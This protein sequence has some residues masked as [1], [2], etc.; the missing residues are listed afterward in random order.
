MIFHF[1][2]NQESKLGS[3]LIALNFVNRVPELI[4]L[5]FGYRGLKY[6]VV[7]N[8]DFPLFYLFSCCRF[9]EDI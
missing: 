5:I 8:S 6:A 4:R 3:D 2:K 9:E 1:V 7:I